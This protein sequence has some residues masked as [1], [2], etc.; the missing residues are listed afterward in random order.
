MR[1]IIAKDIRDV[2]GLCPHWCIKLE[3]QGKF[4]KRIRLGPR[5]VAWLEHEVHEW[6]KS[7]ARVDA[8]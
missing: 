1:V 4:P 8:A 3:K 2:T 7:R 5:R 6:L